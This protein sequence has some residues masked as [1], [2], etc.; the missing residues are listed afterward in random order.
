MESKNEIRFECM[1]GN[2]KRWKEHPLH[3]KL[4]ED[5]TLTATKGERSGQGFIIS[6]IMD[7]FIHFFRGCKYCRSNSPTAIHEPR[8]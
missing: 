1:V 5:L 2:L 6:F 8:R 7:R 3:L 4:N